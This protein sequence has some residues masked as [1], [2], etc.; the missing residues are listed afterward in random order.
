MTNQERIIAEQ[1]KAEL[2]REINRY[3]ISIDKTCFVKTKEEKD[4]LYRLRN[5]WKIKIAS[6]Y[7]STTMKIAG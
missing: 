4:K 7:Q 5:A 3:K 2:Q 1:R 6:G